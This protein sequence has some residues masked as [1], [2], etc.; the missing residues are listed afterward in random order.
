[1]V[2]VGPK[3]KTL[4]SKFFVLYNF[5]NKIMQNSFLLKKIIIKKKQQKKTKNHRQL[6]QCR[7][8][9]TVHIKHFQTK[10]RFNTAS[11]LSIPHTLM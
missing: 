9:H 4:L 5:Y 8:N 11:E 1:M 2:L 6:I 7:S 3:T 10:Q